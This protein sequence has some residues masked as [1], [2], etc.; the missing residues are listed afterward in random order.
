MTNF[1]KRQEPSVEQ[2]LSRNWFGEACKTKWMSFKNLLFLTV[3]LSRDKITRER[4]G[5]PVASV[6]WTSTQLFTFTLHILEVP[7]C[8]NHMLRSSLS[9]LEPRWSSGEI[10]KGRIYRK[11]KGRFSWRVR[12]N[13]LPLTG[14]SSL[15]H[16]I[17]S[18]SSHDFVLLHYTLYSYSDKPELRLGVERNFGDTKARTRPEI[19]PFTVDGWHCFKYWTPK[20]KVQLSF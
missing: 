11:L 18:L 4:E 17:C 10:F 8:T 1:D 20:F 15:Q 7:S 19:L 16:L 14:T 5:T 9:I 13:L 2:P 12:L 6:S 3:A